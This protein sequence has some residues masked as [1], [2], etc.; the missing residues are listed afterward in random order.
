MAELDPRAEEELL[1]FIQG[2]DLELTGSHV[3]TDSQEVL[4]PAGATLELIMG[5]VP[6]GMAVEGFTLTLTMSDTSIVIGQA[7]SAAGASLVLLTGPPP[8]LTFSTTLTVSPPPAHL[9]PAGATGVISTALTSVVINAA[10]T[11]LAITASQPTTDVLGPCDWIPIACN[12]ATW[13]QI[14]CP[15][16]VEPIILRVRPAAAE[17]A[18]TVE[19]ASIAVEL[20]EEP[21]EEWGPWWLDTDA[22][23]YG[24]HEYNGTGWDAVPQ[25][26]IHS[27]S[28]A[29][30]VYHDVSSGWL[31]RRL[32]EGLTD[33]TGAYHTDTTLD[34]YLNGVHVEL[35]TPVSMQDVA[36]FINLSPSHGVTARAVPW[37]AKIPGNP[38]EYEYSNILGVRQTLKLTSNAPIDFT[39]TAP[40]TLS[41]LGIRTE[42]DLEPIGTLGADG[43]YCALFELDEDGLAGSR[44]RIFQ[45]LRNHP[46]VTRTNVYSPQLP[47]VEAD[48]PLM[49][50]YVGS[51]GHQGT[52][53]LTAWNW[54]GARPTT[55]QL[56]WH[57]QALDGA[58]P[59][60]RVHD[61]A[62]WYPSGNSGI[63]GP[64][65]R[66]TDYSR[67]ESA[68]NANMGETISVYPGSGGGY[69]YG[70]TYN[71]MR[72]VTWAD[73]N[74]S[75]QYRISIVQ[76]DGY[77]VLANPTSTAWVAWQLDNPVGVKGRLVNVADLSS[78]P[79]P[80]GI[81]TQN[82][83]A[84]T[85]GD[86]WIDVDPTRT[87]YFALHRYHYPTSTWVPWTCAYYGD[88]STAD[89][90]AARVDVEWLENIVGG[91]FDI[92]LRS[93]HPAEDIGLVYGTLTYYAQPDEPIPSDPNVKTFAAAGAT[94]DL[95]GEDTSVETIG[96]IV[97]SLDVTGGDLAFNGGTPEVITVGDVSAEVDP[98]GATIALIG[99]TST[100]EMVEPA[101]PALYRHWR[102]YSFA[103]SGNSSNAGL[104]EIQLRSTIG[105]AN[106]VSGGTITGTG[107]P[108]AAWDGNTGSAWNV[109][110]FGTPFWTA[111]DLGEGND[112]EVAEMVVY[113]SS[114]AANRS[115]GWFVLSG[116]HDGTTWEEPTIY[117]SPT[118]WV[119]G[120][121][122]TF[123]RHDLIDPPP[124]RYWR[125][126]V[127]T[128]MGNNWVGA[129]EIEFRGTPGGADMTPVVGGVAFSSHYVAPGAANAFDDTANN[130]RTDTLPPVYVG[131]DFTTPVTINEVA[132]T[133][134]SGQ[135]PKSGWIQYSHDGQQWANHY[136]F[137]VTDLTWTA[138]TTKLFTNTA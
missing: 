62:V 53:N 92:L 73:I 116:S 7:L 57:I 17:F 70:N 42:P 122:K 71:P 51:G 40:A 112:Q 47:F 106:F 123:R 77:P 137:D 89:T 81:L 35:P 88:L 134:R 46:G 2:A 6:P 31:S 115:P 14:E 84:R 124:A 68:V 87:D 72:L 100:I 60:T 44:V 18:F 74:N 114:I 48:A 8:D 135:N 83:E 24:L 93:E 98:A 130:F 26:R 1:L 108:A 91:N 120:T 94:L 36:A 104:N 22:S 54:T 59:A 49:W 4:E 27:T 65:P 11:A 61:L 127:A 55:I 64:L 99:E 19:P 119:I 105:G 20:V 76:P 86:V 5:E 131:Y 13:V 25:N 52:Q 34:L 103:N 101:A 15:V 133:S 79:A 117:G 125:V 129:Q 118:G 21:Q 33:P 128:S 95:S 107:T 75:E 113:P 23:T 56:G 126:W 109:T 97:L 37:S 38:E 28:E 111:I 10:G 132:W 102:F 78:F 32:S 69:L 110:S 3:G 136:P 16:C 41:L 39:G 66:F 85:I 30:H 50:Q 121:P 58:D 29:V 67:F 63:S 82:D 96:P 45:K 12:V 80:T 138:G 9:V 90:T 43:D